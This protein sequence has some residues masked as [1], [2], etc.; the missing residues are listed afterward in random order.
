MA[1]HQCENLNAACTCLMLRASPSCVAQW[2]SL[3]LGEFFWNFPLLFFVTTDFKESDQMP[4]VSL[5]SQLNQLQPCSVPWKPNEGRFEI[6]LSSRV[7]PSDS[8]R[9]AR[10]LKRVCEQAVNKKNKFSAQ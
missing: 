9:S 5:S 1:G 3:A 4:I 8:P 10:E 6:R 7:K 2:F